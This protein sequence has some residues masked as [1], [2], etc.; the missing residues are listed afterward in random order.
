MNKEERR[1]RALTRKL[2]SAKWFEYNDAMVEL[3]AKGERAVP[4]LVEALKSESKEARVRAAWTLSEIGVP[5][6]PALIELLLKESIT[7]SERFAA[8]WTLTK[9][10]MPAVELMS[11]R[12]KKTKS[13]RLREAMMEVIGR[14]VAK[15]ARTSRVEACGMKTFPHP[16][17][18][19]PRQQIK[20][21]VV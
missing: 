9:I 4:A 10:G 2:A 17:T 18:L 11:A 21:L 20:R 3:R 1:I 14:I 15:T 12:V 19:Q 7:A 6:V 13:E 8:V 16:A 5:A